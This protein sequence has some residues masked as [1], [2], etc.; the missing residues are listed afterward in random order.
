[1]REHPRERELR[2]R[3]LLTGRHHPHAFHQREVAIEV[4]GIK[5]RRAPAEI[6]RV[7]LGGTREG[8]REEPTP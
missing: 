6:I 3:A 5:A 7:E 4:L 1:L 8:T 2:G